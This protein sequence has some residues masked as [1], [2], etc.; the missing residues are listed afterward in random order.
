MVSGLAG[1][2]AS[3]ASGGAASTSAPVVGLWRRVFAFL[4]R[5]WLRCRRRPAPQAAQA[6]LPQKFSLEGVAGVF[7]G[8]ADGRSSSWV[9]SSVRMDLSILLLASRTNARQ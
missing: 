1:D 6:F 8:V 3:R 9:S 2:A 4:V 5:L 7:P